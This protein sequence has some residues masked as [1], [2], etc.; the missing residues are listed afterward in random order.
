MVEGEDDGEIE[1]PL[2]L[3]KPAY[4]S[5]IKPSTSLTLSAFNQEDLVSM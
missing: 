4:S 1:I 5:H 3:F 2:T